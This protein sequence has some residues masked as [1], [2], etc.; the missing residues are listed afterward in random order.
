MQ[1]TQLEIKNV[2]NLTDI[3]LHPASAI[4]FLTG[5]NGSGKSSILEAVYLLSSGR[6]YR[7]HLANELINWDQE[8]LMVG[9]GF[10]GSHFGQHRAGLAKI[11]NGPMR[12]RL[13]QQDLK[14]TSEL[15]RLLPVKIIHPDMHELVRGG[16]SIRRKFLDWGVFHV[17]PNFLPEW[18]RYQYVL[19]QRNNLLKSHF[20]ANELLAWTRELAVAGEQLDATRQD[21]LAHLRPVFAQWAQRFEIGESIE[22]SYRRGWD[23]NTDL[24]DALSKSEKTCLRY[25]TTSVGPHRADLGLLYH[26]TPAKQSVSRGQQ[27]LLVYALVFSQLDLYKTLTGDVAVLLCDDPEAELDEFHQNLLIEAIRG[28]KIQCFITGNKQDTW[29]TGQNDAMFHVELGKVKRIE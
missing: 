15:A 10:S 2:R 3:S 5:P 1:I 4:N 29:K 18:K 6:S 7:T 24:A 14:S 20:D 25:K 27:K 17:E 9:A 8:Q 26:D 12:I 16:P 21:Y 28:L 11:K 19:G 22:V 13:D 23:K